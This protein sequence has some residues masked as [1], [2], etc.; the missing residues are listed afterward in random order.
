M[1]GDRVRASV[2][3]KAKSVGFPCREVVAGSRINPITPTICPAI[4]KTTDA[5]SIHSSL[6]R[7][8]LRI[9]KPQCTLRSCLL[10]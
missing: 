1:R 8:D 7:D 5:T 6:R 2:L 9:N 3:E 4:G 10:P